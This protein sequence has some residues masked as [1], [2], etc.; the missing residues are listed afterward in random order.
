MRADIEGH[1]SSFQAA[2]SRNEPAKLPTLTVGRQTIHVGNCLDYLQSQRAETFDVIVTSPPYN[3]GVAYNSYHDRLSRADYLGWMTEIGKQLR[4]VLK[5]MGSFFL[6]VG[7]TCSDPWIAMDVA[8]AIR[9]TFQL[10][11]HIIWVKSI[12][13]EDDTVGHFKPINSK[14]YLNNNHESI[15]HFTKDGNSM[16]DKLAV[17][18]PY[19]DKSNVERWKRASGD[20]RCA[21]NTWF[22]PYETVVSRSQKYD[23]PAGFPAALPERCIKLHGKPDAVVFDPFL[24]AGTTLVAAARLGLDGHG[25]EL[26]STYAS[27]AAKRLQAELGV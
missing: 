24:G 21:G 1:G 6:N 12:S 18:V 17:G 13:I 4:R 26:D 27:V 5:P 19:K 2:R 8:N 16:V 22:I 25:V 7:S 3:I 14:R 20:R 15:F 23:H 9:G 11:N 10:Q